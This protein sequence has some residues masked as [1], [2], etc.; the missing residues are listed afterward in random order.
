MGNLINYRGKNAIG[1][2]SVQVIWLYGR[3]TQSAGALELLP[4]QTKAVETN[5]DEIYRQGIGNMQDIKSYS[6]FA[7]CLPAQE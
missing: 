3:H 1:G 6:L 4:G 7:D 2:R 5:S